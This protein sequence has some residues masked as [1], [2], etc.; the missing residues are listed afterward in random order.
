MTEQ[1]DPA[2][3][4][5]N[6]SGKW[7]SGYGVAPCPICQTERRKDQNALTINVDGGRLLLHCKKL[8]C[9]FRD[10]LTAAGITAG[11]FEI[12]AMALENAKRQRMDTERKKR[13]RAKSLWDYSNPIQGTNG[14]AYLRGRGITCALPASLR[15]LPETFHAPSLQY[16]SAMIAKVS[17]TDAVHRTFFTKQGVRLDKVPNGAKDGSHKMMLSKCSGGAVRLSDTDGP[18]VVCEGIETGL[19]L[20]SGLLTGPHTVWAALSTSG[21]KGL[22]LPPVVGDLIVAVDNDENGAGQKAGAE[23]SAKAH[24]LGWNVSTLA[25]P[26]IGQDWNDVL[27]NEVAA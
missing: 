5:G 3:L 4:T 23:L 16:Q 14:E 26:D 18:L 25:P 22:Q 19:S 24:A 9:D 13:D 11:T 12:D 27:R 7:Y 17:P 2:T 6:L 8:G 1:I 10:I 21:I 20:L 15:W